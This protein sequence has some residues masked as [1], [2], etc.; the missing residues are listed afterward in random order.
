[1]SATRS[2]K[3]DY[4]FTGSGCAALSLLMR[5]IQSGKFA[6]KKILLIDKEPKSRNDR[7]WCF[8][9]KGNGF[10][11]DIVYRKW[12]VVNFYSNTFS[13]ALEIAP[14]QYKMIRGIDFYNYCFEIIRK[15]HNIETIY[16]FV[17]FD[18]SAI[19]VDDVVLETN[20]AIVFNSLYTL[21]SKGNGVI[22]LRQHFK[23]W[24]IETETPSFNVEQARLMDF[25]VHQDNGTAFSYL[26]PLSET[27]ALIEYT[28]F[29]EN[30]LNPSQYNDGLK[31]YIHDVLKIENYRITEEEFGCIPMTNARFSF[32]EKGRYNIGTAGGQTKASSGYT[33]RF[34]QKNSEKILI[35][36]L[37][38]QP[39]SQ[40]G[41][42]PGRFHFYD[43]ILLRLL[44]ENKLKGET[45]FSQL[46]ERNK[47]TQIL[48]FLDNETSLA[49][50]LKIISSLPTMPF[51]KAAI[52]K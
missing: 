23:G 1:M 49:E 37:S 38:G 40:L 9:E 18:D 31:T 14:Y 35:Q 33:F 16:G 21:P 50:E 19:L 20:G 41:K 44:K 32:F 34:I 36:L 29:S 48:K 52:S 26:L 15:Q 42:P 12:P 8:W 46:F 30:L 7:T 25:R 39:L 11:E 27:K 6:D 22:I 47:A 17:R 28:L 3:F 24:V 45:I 4:I 13:G 43:T 5:M 10:F 2:K 51:L